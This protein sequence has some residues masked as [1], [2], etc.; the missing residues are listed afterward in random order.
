MYLRHVL[1]GGAG[2]PEDLTYFLPR[3]FELWRLYLPTGSVLDD[4]FFQKLFSDGFFHQRLALDHREACVRFVDR[5]FLELIDG[6]PALDA[7]WSEG[8]RSI[9]FAWPAIWYTRGQL[10]PMKD[11]WDHWWGLRTTGRARAAAQFASC[12]VLLQESNPFF[13]AWTPERGGGPPRLESNS[14]GFQEGWLLENVEEFRKRV[15]ISSL[16]GLIRRCG[17]A[18]ASPGESAMV[19]TLAERLESLPEVAWSN[20]SELDS[21]ISAAPKWLIVR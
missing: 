2:S 11:L 14:L 6:L 17:Q 3:L 13:P 9:A 16:V 1:N 4:C 18:L 15:T 7:P 21:S 10:G 5:T 20:L 19:Q 8:A 12:L